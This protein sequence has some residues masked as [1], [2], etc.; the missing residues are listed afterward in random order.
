MREFPA[1]TVER[2]DAA[3][4]VINGAVERID[5]LETSLTNETELD[6][7]RGFEGE[8]AALYF[9]VMDSLTV[10]DDPALRFEKRSRRPPKNRFNALLSFGYALLLSDCLAAL[11]AVG[12]D[13]WAGYLHVERPGRPSLALDLMEEF[14][15]FL[16]DRMVLALINR[17]QIGVGDFIVD[18]AGGVVLTDVARKTFLVEYQNRKSREIQHPLLEEK[19]PLGLLPHLQARLLARAIRGDLEEYP[20]FLFK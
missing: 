16:V 12:L 5:R 18:A 7:T 11:Q 10:I 20:P 19:A 1:P 2:E 9:G 3:A 14:R 6:R 17:R 4:E 15:A 13:P 8:A